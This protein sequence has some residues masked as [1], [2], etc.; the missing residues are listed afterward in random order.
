MCYFTCVVGCKYVVSIVLSLRLF[1]MMCVFVSVWSFSVLSLFG[2]GFS[3][4]SS[5]VLEVLRV[6]ILVNLPEEFHYLG[7]ASKIM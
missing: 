6:K 5:T 2:F 3:S 7:P 1:S 4:A